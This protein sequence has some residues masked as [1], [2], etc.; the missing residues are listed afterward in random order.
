MTLPTQDN[1]QN[2]TSILRVL[3]RKREMTTQQLM[4]ETGLAEDTI[5]RHLQDLNAMG[6]LGIKQV[7]VSH[8]FRRAFF[9]RDEI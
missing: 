9:L 4:H 5:R 7:K 8:S 3:S 6:M 1:Q 2:R